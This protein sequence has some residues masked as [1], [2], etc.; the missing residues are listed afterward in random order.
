MPEL[1]Q[2][3]S[4]VNGLHFLSQMKQKPKKTSSDP[5]RKI[6]DNFERFLDF[7]IQNKVRVSDTNE[8]IGLKYL[9]E[10]NSIMIEPIG[11][12]QQRPQIK[13]Y[14]HICG[15]FILLRA[16]GMAIVARDEKKPYLKVDSQL[17]D[18]WRNLSDW[19]KYFAL[20]NAWLFHATDEIVGE[21]AQLHNFYYSKIMDF[22]DTLL[23][24]T[25]FLDESSDDYADRLKYSA[26]GFYNLVLC[27][28]FNFIELSHGLSMDKKKWKPI[29][30]KMTKWG[31]YF[32]K[33]LNNHECRLH[34]AISN[35]PP[36]SQILKSL[37][38]IK[39]FF[40]YSRPS[41]GSHSIELK[42]ILGKTHRK[43][44]VP[45][46][47]DFDGLA[48]LIIDDYGFDFD[49][50]YYFMYRNRFGGF[51]RIDHH[52]LDPDEDNYNLDLPSKVAGD[53]MLK[54]LYLSEGMIIHFRFDMGACWDFKIII[55]GMVFDSEIN[56][57]K[58]LEKKGKPPEQY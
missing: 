20:L 36:L 47:M 24:N 6:I 29:S 21:T 30:A 34:Y 25:K 37:P 57:A 46:S 10:I 52:Y 5:N 44:L 40:D 48:L 18:Q 49:H 53:V 19:E 56:E 17:L 35:N 2:N 41:V 50:L 11:L 12:E 27:E 33:P 32:W 55:E 58:L 45:N 43:Y 26:N 3:K 13:S 16:S 28:L 23:T 31:I 4:P 9:N 39:N 51:S 38:P 42:I 22:T 14:P 54:D 7:F 15:L 1:E 8:V